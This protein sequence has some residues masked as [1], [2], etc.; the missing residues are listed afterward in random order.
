LGDGL[1]S[2]TPLLVSNKSNVAYVSYDSSRDYNLP[3]IDFFQS[4]D[5]GISWKSIPGIAFWSGGC[6][7]PYSD[8][9][10]EGIYLYWVC[11]YRYEYL[12]N[13]QSDIYFSRFDDGVISPTVQGRLDQGDDQYSHYSLQPRICK[14][15]KTL[16]VAWTEFRD[17]TNPDIYF[18][19]CRDSGMTW[20]N[21]ALPLYVDSSDHTGSGRVR[22]AAT[23]Q[24]FYAVWHRYNPATDRFSVLFNS[25]TTDA[26]GDVVATGT[27][28]Q[29]DSADA[30]ARNPEIACDGDNIYVIWQDTRYGGSDILTRLSVDRGKTWGEEIRLNTNAAGY[31]YA[32]NPTGAISGTW[33]YVLWEDYRDGKN[34]RFEARQ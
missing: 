6:E 24:T 10:A 27:A 11:Q 18:N 13:F 17:G 4:K 7:M 28:Q 15:P 34:V 29:L 21:P 3:R 32:G 8:L 26:T 12:G 23:P 25:V 1:D 31:S 19:Y 5:K 16:F 20:Q 2:R 22:V 14:D 30:D 9:V 33:A